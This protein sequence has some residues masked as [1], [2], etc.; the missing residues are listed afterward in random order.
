[1]MNSYVCSSFCLFVIKGEDLAPSIQLGHFVCSIFD[2]AASPPKY[3][4]RVQF[5]QQAI[6]YNL[7]NLGYASYESICSRLVVFTGYGPDVISII[8]G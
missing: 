6:L 2:I 8:H 1:M 7:Y 4:L 5:P 3:V